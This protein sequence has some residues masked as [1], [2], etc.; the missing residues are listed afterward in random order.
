MQ[1]L[2]MLQ[3]L[4]IGLKLGGAIAWSW[5]WVLSPIWIIILSFGALAIG[6]TYLGYKIKGN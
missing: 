2:G 1:F 3:V 6:A 4:F 5:C